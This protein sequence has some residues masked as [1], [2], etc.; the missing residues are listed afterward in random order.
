MILLVNKLL[1][2]LDNITLK[3]KHSFNSVCYL[4]REN[5]SCCGNGT[6]K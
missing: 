6:G 2:T 4:D 5:V 3:P 1:K